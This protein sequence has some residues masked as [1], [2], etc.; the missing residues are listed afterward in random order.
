M[1][2]KVGVIVLVEDVTDEDG[3]GRMLYS[4]RTT[5]NPKFYV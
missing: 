1:D 4:K 2:T 5:T 3:N